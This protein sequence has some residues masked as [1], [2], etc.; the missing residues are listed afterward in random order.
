[1]SDIY[2]LLGGLTAFIAQGIWS[3]I[4]MAFIML[5]FCHFNLMGNWNKTLKMLKIHMTILTFS[6]VLVSVIMIVV[7]F[8][9]SESW[10][11]D[12]AKEVAVLC[13]YIF[14]ILVN[15][16]VEINMYCCQMEEI[17]EED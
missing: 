17:S 12:S 10:K 16:S 5:W 3:F 11:V 6:G 9:N 4:F 13:F 15:L 7:F 2:I 14:D 1:M 8:S